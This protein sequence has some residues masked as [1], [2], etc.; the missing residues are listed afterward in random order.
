MRSLLVVVLAGCAFK[1]GLLSDTSSETADAANAADATDAT[2]D[3]GVGD[4]A[5]SSQVACHTDSQYIP[6]PVTSI[7]YKAVAT[8]TSWTA[9]QADCASAGGHL[10]VINDA[11]EDMY[12]DSLLASEIWIGYSDQAVEGTFVWVAGLTSS[13]TNWRPDG[14]PNDGG[15]SEPQDCAEI[16]ETGGFW[17]DDNCPELDPYV[18]ECPP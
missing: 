16:D 10:V 18:C 1:P 17:N 8:A 2:I 13:Y 12:I 3:G 11:A 6:N 15:G 14:N 9:A 5:P 4:D 7:R